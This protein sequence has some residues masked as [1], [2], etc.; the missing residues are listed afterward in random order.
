MPSRRRR[1]RA[2]WCA[3][4]RSSSRGTCIPGPGR[5]VRPDGHHTGRS[6]NPLGLDRRDPA[7]KDDITTINLLNLP[8]GR[9]VIIQLSSKD[10]VHSL[11]MPQMPVKQDAVPGIIQP[12][13][14]TPT[15]TGRWELACSQLCGL[16]HY[17]MK[18]SS[19]RSS[20]RRGW[21]RKRHCCRSSRCQALG[22]GF[23]L[24][25]LGSSL[26]ESPKPRAQSQVTSGA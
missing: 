9:P 2:P 10:V 8:V 23:R 6:D 19:R 20:T 26:P 7:A 5:C 18:A 22:L 21:M 11:G 17:R 24:W 16:A 14:F 3:W 4:S 12:V 25:A 1:R 15:Q 13:W